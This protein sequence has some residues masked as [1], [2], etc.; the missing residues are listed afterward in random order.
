MSKCFSPIVFHGT[1]QSE[2][3]SVISLS[4]SLLLALVNV[5]PSSRYYHKQLK[6][7]LAFHGCSE[8]PRIVTVVHWSKLLRRMVDTFYI[9]LHFPPMSSKMAAPLYALAGLPCWGRAGFGGVCGPSCLPSEGSHSPADSV[10]EPRMQQPPGASTLKV[11]TS[12]STRAPLAVPTQRCPQ[13]PKNPSKQASCP[14][15]S[16]V[17][18]Q[19]NHG[20]VTKGLPS[21]NCYRQTLILWAFHTT[22][23]S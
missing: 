1:V 21:D 4:K 12:T 23:R 6:V 13:A 11:S 15:S 14:A 18:E 22:P 8:C 9:L 17:R 7:N 3:P 19:E 2:F 16:E 20:R 5:S 10:L